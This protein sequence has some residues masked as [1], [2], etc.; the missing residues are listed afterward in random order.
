MGSSGSVE[1]DFRQM[2]IVFGSIAV[3]LLALVLLW[4]WEA[5]ADRKQLA[6]RENLEITN[7]AGQTISVWARRGIDAPRP[8]TSIAPYRPVDCSPPECGLQ[9]G[10]TRS[11]TFDRKSDS[12]YPPVLVTAWSA[13]TGRIL[14]SKEFTI[15]EMEMNS[16]RVEIVDQR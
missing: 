7:Q 6:L 2:F 16:W 10:I 4:D 9:S 12:A 5:E 1:M 11:W 8:G 13:D 14:Y 3:F 15:D